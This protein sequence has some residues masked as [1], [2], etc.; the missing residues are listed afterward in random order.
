M[1]SMKC[2]LT[3]LETGVQ[4]GGVTC[5]G[6][7]A[8]QPQSI[9][10]SPGLL[11]PGSSLCPTQPASPAKAERRTGCPR[12]LE[13]INMKFKGSPSP[14]PWK[15]D[16]PARIVMGNCLPEYEGPGGRERG[17]STSDYPLDLPG[18]QFLISKMG[19][20]TPTSRPATGL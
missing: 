11:A 10:E 9:H 4:R 5:M 3:D 15:A 8:G 16:F 20:T 14:W 2:H 7:T 19:I 12:R 17:K 1:T 13:T 18:T 6:H